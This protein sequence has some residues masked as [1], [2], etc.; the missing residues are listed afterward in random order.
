VKRALDGRLFRRV[1]RELPGEH[2]RVLDVGGGSGWL[3]DVVREQD[4]RVVETHE[5]D[6]DESARHAA[7]MAGHVFH[8]TP[9]ES[10]AADGRFDLV[11]LLNLIEH[12]ADPASVLRRV[13]DLLSPSGMLLIKT[14]NTDTLDRRLFQNHNWGGFHC[15]RHWVLFTMPALVQLAGHCGFELVWARYTQGAPQWAN[16]ILGWLA[17]RRLV[18]VSVERPMHTH[19]LLSP[20]LALAAAFDLLRLPFA[21]TA[22]MFVLL[23]KTAEPGK[24]TTVS[25]PGAKDSD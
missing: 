1:M 24:Q 4:R 11:L 25:V 10:F 15:P 16:S 7:E 3:L 9:I 20:L 14:P 5:V 21:P 8:C 23:K 18:R 12:V 13:A 19:P 22:Q 6:L 2:L 17:D